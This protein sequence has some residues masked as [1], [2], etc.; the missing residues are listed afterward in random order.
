MSVF[1]VWWIK[2]EIWMSSLY[3]VVFL[4]F[5][6]FISIIILVVWLIANLV[7]GLF[8]LVRL[9]MKVGFKFIL[10]IDIWVII[11]L[12]KEFE[13]VMINVSFY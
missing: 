9:K 8:F 4:K 2:L 13:I 6:V 11:I 1:F 3:L 10:W 7:L 5:N 12:G